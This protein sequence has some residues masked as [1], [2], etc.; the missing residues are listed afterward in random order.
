MIKQ[1]QNMPPLRMLI[2]LY[3]PKGERLPVKPGKPAEPWEKDWDNDD[4]QGHGGYF[5]RDVHRA[6][7]DKKPEGHWEWVKSGRGVQTYR[8]IVEKEQLVP[9]ALARARSVKR[10]QPSRGGKK[11]FLLGNLEKAAYQYWVG[12]KE[13]I[14]PD[15]TCRVCG[16]LVWTGAERKKHFETKQ[17][18]RVMVEAI[19]A[20]QALKGC[21]CACGCGKPQK[22]RCWGL[23]FNSQ[24]CMEWFAYVSVGTDP[25]LV[26]EIRRQ[27]IKWEFDSMVGGH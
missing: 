19:R 21:T 20:F 10:E 27:R 9:K 18:G 26:A 2:S 8:W 3:A 5:M 13:E 17:C 16:A 24:D 22:Q 11:E 15:A 4:W 7:L 25:A 12:H 23:G 6:A 14:Y 1:F